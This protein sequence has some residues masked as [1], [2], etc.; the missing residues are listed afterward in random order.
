MI[1]TVPTKD[2]RVRILAYD[3]II[4]VLFCN[5]MLGDTHPSPERAK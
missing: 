3:N 2:A 5:V 4:C 1:V